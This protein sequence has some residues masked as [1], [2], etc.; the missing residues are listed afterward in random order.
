VPYHSAVF[1][2]P[3]HILDGLESA[4]LSKAFVRE[5]LLSRSDV[6]I[7][8]T[9]QAGQW[10]LPTQR[11]IIRYEGSETRAAHLSRRSRGGQAL[12]EH[13]GLGDS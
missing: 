5:H 4:A 7:L 8:V 10:D 12:A 1:R 9:R 6:L 3:T 13:F 2:L 11:N